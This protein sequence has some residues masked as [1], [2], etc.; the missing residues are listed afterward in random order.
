MMHKTAAGGPLWSLLAR[1]QDGDVP[2][3]PELSLQIQFAHWQNSLTQR[4]Q[5]GGPTRLPIL[6]CPAICAK[7]W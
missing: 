6:Q 3:L 2:F 7:P 4:W 5:L 1:Q